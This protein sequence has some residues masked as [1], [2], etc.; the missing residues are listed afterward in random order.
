MSTTASIILAVIFLI[1][2]LVLGYFIRKNSSEKEINGAKNYATQIIND[3]NKEAESKK[4]EILI[5]AKDEIFNMKNKLIKENRI[6][7]NDLDKQK[8]R[9]ELKE[10]SLEMKNDSLDKKH[11]KL[12]AELNKAEELKAQIQAVIDQKEVELQKIA[13]LTSDE[14]KDIVLNEVRDNTI[15]EQASIIKEI[16]ADTREKSEKYAREIISTSIQR[17]AADQ[18]S[19]TTVSVV[20]LPTDDMK[21]RIIGR[22]GRNIRAFENLTGV[23]LIIDDT[24]EAVVLSAF[25]PIRREIARIALEKLI[26]DGRI[27]PTRIEEMVEKAT[28]EVEETIIEKGQE[29]CDE[30]NVHGLHPEIVKLLGKLH[31]RTSYGQNVLKHSIEVSNISGMLA[32]ELGANVKLAKR[33]GLLHDIGKAIDHEIEGPHVE[34]GVNA[35]KKYKEPKEV[36]NCIESH[37][38]DAEPEYIEAV[39]VQAADAI[40][41]ARPGAR[42]ESMENYIQ[43]LEKLEEIANSFKGIENSYAIQAGR[44]LR[45]A[46]IP[47]EV[48]DNSMVILAKE[49]A[50]KI[51]D[52]LEYPGQ[53]KVNVIR[54]SRAS[55]YA[56]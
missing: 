26:I 25:N 28:K 29:A 47:E 36:I 56:K 20:N 24:P 31:Y 19:E 8:E 49:I 34:L 2:G 44:E 39:L 42:R 27:H 43:R 30:T 33:G 38:G 21:G 41:A 22:E 23:D 52:E 40:S 12:D 55:D 10:A 16:E 9:I 37:H 6:R 54:E 50:H 11:K 51:E 17:Y 53:I 5:E 45:V 32:A 35:A 4:K 46:V 48:D 13:G 18:V 14:A 7:Q 3:A 1:I 15:Q